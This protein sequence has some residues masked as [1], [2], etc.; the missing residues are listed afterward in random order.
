[1]KDDN[2]N[3]SPQESRLKW[4]TRRG[5]LELDVLLGD[6]FNKGYSKLSEENKILFEKLLHSSDPELFAWL[7]GQEDP[8]DAELSKIIEVIRQ[9]VKSRF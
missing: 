2:K 1:M 7:L 4:A 5:M 8:Q 3:N 9:H 6:F